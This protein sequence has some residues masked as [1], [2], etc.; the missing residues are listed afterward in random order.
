MAEV[1]KRRL[2]LV[3]SSRALTSAP[4]ELRSC[5]FPGTIG[6]WPIQFWVYV[7]SFVAK[8][9][10]ALALS[11]PVLLQPVLFV[12]V[13]EENQNQ[14]TSSAPNVD[15]IRKRLAKIKAQ[16]FQG[17]NHLCVCQAVVP[18]IVSRPLPA[19]WNWTRTLKRELGTSQDTHFQPD[20]C[21]LLIL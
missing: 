17:E 2:I 19:L 13:Q 14:N 7:L 10:K 3:R 4:I 9:C 11:Y 12:Q 6:F 16:A 8:L 5:S 1:A 15:E 21:Y 20:L 18:Y